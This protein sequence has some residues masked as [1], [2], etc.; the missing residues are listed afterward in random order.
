MGRDLGVDSKTESGILM[1]FLTA[2]ESHILLWLV[3]CLACIS[4]E[5]YAQPQEF[6]LSCPKYGFLQRFT[7]E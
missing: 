7:D 1:F 2:A 3:G 4:I 6:K 5:I